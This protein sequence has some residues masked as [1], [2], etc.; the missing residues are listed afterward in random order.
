LTTKE[1][2]K[3]GEIKLLTEYPRNGTRLKSY[4]KECDSERRKR[5]YY[6]NHERELANKKR[7]YYENFDYFAEYGRKWRAENPERVVEYNKQYRETNRD[8]RRAANSLRKA[9]KKGADH[10]SIAE[11]VWQM[12]EDQD[13]LCAYCESPLFGDFHV[14]HMVPLSKGGRHHWSNLAIA[15]P[16]CNM[17]K[18]TK[19]AEEF[20]SKRS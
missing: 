7:Y 3:C 20:M 17:N 1:C 6:E 13:W 15:C 9:L 8:K 10:K 5:Q 16:G 12:A 2:T 19:T 11:D 18:R 4:C 14:D